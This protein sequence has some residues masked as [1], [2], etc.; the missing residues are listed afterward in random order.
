MDDTIIYASAQ[1]FPRSL[2][3]QVRCNCMEHIEVA[4]KAKRHSSES[5]VLIVGTGTGL[6]N[7][8]RMVH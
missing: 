1:S 3:L 2:L 5:L 4:V 8:K 7:M 6:Q